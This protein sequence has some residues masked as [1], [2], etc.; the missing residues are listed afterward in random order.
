MSNSIYLLKKCDF[1]NISL[2][3]AMLTLNLTQ[4]VYSVEY[5]TL[6]HG[7]QWQVFKV[8]SILF[9]VLFLMEKS[10]LYAKIT[11]S[12]K[13]LFLNSVLNMIEAFYFHSYNNVTNAH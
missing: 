7:R 12:P 8:T 6:L 9:P 10:I 2:I 4:A 3:L 13:K 1:T 5:N 11:V